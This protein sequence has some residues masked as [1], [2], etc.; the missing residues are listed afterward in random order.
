MGAEQ[1]PSVPAVG[2]TGQLRAPRRVAA[3]R[4][5]CYAASQSL[6]PGAVPRGPHRVLY[7][8]PPS[9]AGG[10]LHSS[11]REPDGSATDQWTWDEFTLASAQAIT[12][13]RW[14]GLYDPALLGLGGQVYDFTVDIYPTI[15]AGGQPDVANP[16]LVHYELGSNAGETPAGWWPACQPMTTAFVL[17]TPFQAAAGTKY[18]VPIEA[19]QYGTADW[20]LAKSTGG[21]GSHF[22][23]VRTDSGLIFRFNSGDAAFTLLGPGITTQRL[24]L[25]L[26]LRSAGG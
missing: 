1:A 26:L 20:G 22:E 9:P 12:E 17:P 6:L 2:R 8:Q 16:P 15:A 24:Y 4:L 11:L 25:P 19:W 7:T 14:R 13:V 18:W 10:L 3:L 21:N 23:K 5:P